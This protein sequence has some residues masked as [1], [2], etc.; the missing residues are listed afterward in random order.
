MYN[1]TEISKGLKMTSKPLTKTFLINLAV[2]LSLP[3]Q[4]F[5]SS[6]EK[7]EKELKARGIN[8]KLYHINTNCQ[9]TLHLRL[10]L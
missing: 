1:K 6:A 7:L 9:I 2:L 5:D 8:I 4:K 3:Y 10:I